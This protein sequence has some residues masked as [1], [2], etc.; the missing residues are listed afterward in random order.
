[1]PTKFEEKIYN[2]LRLVPKGKVTTYGQLAKTVESTAYR[3]VGQAMN[4]KSI[5]V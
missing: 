5:Y 1:M 2:K 3:A 4:K